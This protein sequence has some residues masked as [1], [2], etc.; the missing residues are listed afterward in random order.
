MGVSS[1]LAACSLAFFA[2]AIPPM[3]SSQAIGSAEGTD[4]ATEAAGTVFVEDT[5][6]VS[7]GFSI[8]SGPLAPI[9]ASGLGG[10][11]NNTDTIAPAGSNEGPAA[12]DASSET[13][14][15]VPDNSAQTPDATPQE[16]DSPQ[17][18]TT[19]YNEVGNNIQTGWSLGNDYYAYLSNS[20]SGSPVFW[21][22]GPYVDCNPHMWND[23]QQA[24]EICGDTRAYASQYID[25]MN[26]GAS[27]YP[28][29]A[30]DCNKVRDIWS[31]LD[32]AAALYSRFLDAALACPDPHTH[33]DCF[34]SMVQPHIV[35]VK[36]GY[37]TYYTLDYL[38]NARQLLLS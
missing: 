37:D 7:G 27:K 24:Y 19:D 5:D 9:G 1:L 16:P 10:V 18:D 20:V 8:L 30:N 23:M 21:T 33:S 13:I 17:L 31:Q 35:A 2:F 6:D 38:E 32:Q 22:Y 12:T 36:S 25:K 4:P 34:M 26:Y 28:Q 15:P 14:T 11:V 3:L 29:L